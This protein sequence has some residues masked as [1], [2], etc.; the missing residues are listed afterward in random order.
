M[1]TLQV[2][3][4]TSDEE[5]ATLA[6][7]HTLAM[8]DSEPLDFA[9]SAEIVFVPSTATPLQRWKHYVARSFAARHIL[10]L[11]LASGTADEGHAIQVRLPYQ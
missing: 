4:L 10:R 3:Y 7:K 6:R 2:I 5:V 11:A 1:C 9:A 8:G